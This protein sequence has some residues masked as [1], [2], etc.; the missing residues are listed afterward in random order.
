[1]FW[2]KTGATADTQQPGSFVFGGFD[3]AKA[4][5]EGHTDEL[6]FSNSLCSTGMLVTVTDMVLDFANGTQA[7]LFDDSQSI[8]MSACIEPDYPGL[9]TLPYDPYL[10]RFQDLTQ[11]YLTSAYYS[12]YYTGMLYDHPQ[13]AYAYLQYFPH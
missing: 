8:A 2:G 1:M 6:Y 4:S 5:G 10:Q 13:N 7:S 3:R 9:M 12:V 11:H